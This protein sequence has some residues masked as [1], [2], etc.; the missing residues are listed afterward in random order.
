[1]TPVLLT[2]RRAPSHASP[3]LLLAA[4]IVRDAA[5]AL[6][7]EAREASESARYLLAAGRLESALGSPRVAGQRLLLASPALTD[8]AGR[9]RTLVEMIEEDPG[10][11]ADRLR[12]AK[13]LFRALIW[14]PETMPAPRG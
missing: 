10:D 1:M 13:L 12:L 3:E 4:S 6:A 5:E 7:D 2:P 9:N 8:S 14:R 11:D